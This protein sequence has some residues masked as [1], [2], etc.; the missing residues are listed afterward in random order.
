MNEGHL[1]QGLEYL[2]VHE[3][4][5]QVMHCTDVVMDARV[6]TNNH[7][8]GERGEGSLKEEEDREDA[9]GG[10]EGNQNGEKDKGG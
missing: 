2:K 7:D 3:T 6:M 1:T 10:W 9:G 4:L 8:D 5:R